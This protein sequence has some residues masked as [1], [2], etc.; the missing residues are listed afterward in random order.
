[1]YAYTL[2]AAVDPGTVCIKASNKPLCYTT[3][4]DSTLNQKGI[5][6]T[7]DFIAAAYEADP[8]FASFCHSNTHEVGK[9][10]YILFHATGKV[11]L[12]DKASYCGFGFYHGFMEEML[13]ETHNMD[14]ARAFC[15]Y[16]G[17]VV[18]NPPGYAEGA[19][20]HGIGHGVTDGYDPTLW[21]NAV[22]LAAPGLALC[23]TVALTEVFRYRC[24]SGVFN[25][26]ALM[27]RDPTYKL[28]A[29]DDPYK[30]C[31]TAGYNETEQSAC[32]SQM[33][34]LVSFVAGDFGKAISY[35]TSVTAKY[36][37]AAVLNVASIK[38]QR[39]RLGPP[40]RLAEQ[41]KA[42]CGSLAEPERLACINGLVDGIMEH[43][44]PQNQY[45]ELVALC[46]AD[47]G[48]IT[49]PC[50]NRLVQNIDTF[51]SGMLR[52]TACAALPE[53]YRARCTQ[54]S[55]ASQ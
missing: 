3:V 23:K 49:D 44:P 39:L 25:S 37:D 50:Y 55:G 32:Y 38:A 9:A 28:S 42:V 54:P 45:K 11:D 26:V 12:S 21:G 10:A 53:E 20:Y 34:T 29:Q 41:A 30:L 1:M 36:R 43:G 17:T 22:A 6:A 24:A 47:I 40:E 33:D 19:C 48:V 13:A 46:S 7:F 15:A 35:A 31:R 8:A 51:Y 52:E 5:S 18:P 14:E 16:A 2:F 4:I 27:Y